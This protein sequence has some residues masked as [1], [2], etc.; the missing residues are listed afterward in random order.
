MTTMTTASKEANLLSMAAQFSFRARMDKKTNEGPVFERGLGSLVWDVNAKEYLDFNSGQM[1]SALGHNHPTVTAAIR[2]ACDTMLHAHSSHYNVK[3]IE[4]AARLGEIVP[5]PLQKS[6]FGESGA[7]ANEMAMMIARKYTNGFE[8]ASPHVSFHGLSDATRA[9]TFSGWHTGHGHLPGGTYAIVAPYCYRCPLNQTF[10]SCQFACLKTSFELLDA[11]TTGRPAA[12]ITEPLFSAGGVIEPPTGWLKALQEMCRARNM[13]L[14]V[15]EEQTGLGK[16][17]QMF[18]F[19]SE[20]IVPDIITVAKHFGGGVG[21]SA[22]ITT[23]EIEEKVIQSGY[24]ATH[25]HANDP[26]ICAAGV[27]SLDVIRDEDVP[28]KA[29]KIGEQMRE[30][31]EALAQRYELIGDVRGRGQLMGIELVRDR[32][33]KEPATAEGKAIARKCFE[34]GLIFSVRREGSVLRFVPPSTTTEDQIDLAMDRL[35]GAIEH[36]VPRSRA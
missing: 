35:G 2:D 7:D 23:A 24:A 18:G 3:E 32:Y 25:S 1:C 15:D 30:R 31:L 6:L 33:T 19:E 4:L 17:G 22:V 10:P 12:V 5:R 9:V 21:V 8:I 36:A 26:L 11:Q 14:I 16:L 13:L 27:A 20:G 29:R 28:A 34:D